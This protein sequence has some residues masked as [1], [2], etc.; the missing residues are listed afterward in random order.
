MR[1]SLDGLWEN[2]CKCDVIQCLN[3]QKHKTNANNMHE[4]EFG[5]NSER[6]PK[7]IKRGKI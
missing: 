7:K 1:V 3:F 5:Q 2:A 4:K 6:I